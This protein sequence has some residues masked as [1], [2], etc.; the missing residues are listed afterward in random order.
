MDGLWRK[1]ARALAPVFLPI[2]IEEL[3]KHVETW[4]KVDL[5]QDGIVGFGGGRDG[6]AEAS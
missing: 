2:L 5:N 4:I 3:T 1:L 6:E